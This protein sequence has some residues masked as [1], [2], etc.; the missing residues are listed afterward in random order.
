MPDTMSGTNTATMSGMCAPLIRGNGQNVPP[1]TSALGQWAVFGPA[2]QP[3]ALRQHSRA[4][5]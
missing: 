1:C 5:D 2:V 4:K 3:V